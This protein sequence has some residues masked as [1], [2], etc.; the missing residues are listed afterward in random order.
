[1]ERS[2]HTPASTTR[3]GA[4][5][6][7]TPAHPDPY[8]WLAIGVV[9]LF[10]LTL[11]TLLGAVTLIEQQAA[12]PAAPSLASAQEADA[13][14][15]MHTGQVHPGQGVYRQSCA[16]CHGQD[17]EGVPFLGKPLRNSAF[18]QAQSDEELI[19]LI[20]EGRPPNDPANTTGALMPP[21]GAQALDDDAIETVVDYLR[22]MQ[23]PDE[24][25][26]SMAGW[27]RKSDAGT[28]VGGRALE[29]NEHPGYDLYV[30]SCAACHG[31]GAEG[32][33]Q[34]GLPLSTSGFV[35]AQ[36]DKDLI[37]FVKTGRPIWDANNTTGLDMPPKGGNPAITDQDLQAI[38][39]YLRAVQ[40][41]AIG[42]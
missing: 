4:T 2:K 11:P 31:Q 24:P 27:E 28:G 1:M 5:P 7:R 29:L 26:V 19:R 39:D 37:N 25:V 30:A 42:S 10:G 23:D 3:P 20:V 34:L 6:R 16:V 41:E 33:E 21:R 36:S 18:V 8:R 35:K 14:H 40:E 12:S 38:V 17:G 13:T 9:T 15:V 32:I 22:Q